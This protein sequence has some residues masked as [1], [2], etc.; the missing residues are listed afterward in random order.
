ME[1]KSKIIKINNFFR[2][3][4]VV[5]FISTILICVF[6][7]NLETYVLNNPKSIMFWIMLSPFIIY[8]ILV[9]ITVLIVLIECDFTNMAINVFL[10]I[11]FL[12][13]IL[14]IKL[15]NFDLINI[16]KTIYNN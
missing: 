12:F 13:N 3:L 11:P 8:V 14:L 15:L 2:V 5:S 1:K 7:P 4:Q 10:T 16:L 6:K 9:N